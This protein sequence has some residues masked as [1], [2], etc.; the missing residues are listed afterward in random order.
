MANTYTLINKVTVSS[1]SS[2][3]I[4]FTSI[5]QTYTDLVLKISSRA[6]VGE[7]SSG[8]FY[9]VSFN[10]TVNN[11]SGNYIDAGGNGIS[12]SVYTSWGLS[13][14]S[15]FTVNTFSDGELYIPNYA[16]ANYKASI[17]ESVNE[18]NSIYGPRFVMSGALWSDTA[19]I[20]SIKLSPGGG[21]FAQYSTAYLYGI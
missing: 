18:S 3:Y 15:D 11:R 10:N 12:T 5:P 17:L 2:P 14:P 6:T 21:N 7:Y 20:T 16:S 1:S 8:Y 4:E 13:V 19:A 9:N